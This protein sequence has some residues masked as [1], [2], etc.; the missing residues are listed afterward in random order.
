MRGNYPLRR[1]HIN[2]M[3]TDLRGI[4]IF[5]CRTRARAIYV[6]Q[7]EKQTLKERI[8]Q[9]WRNSHNEELRDWIQEFGEHL[10]VYYFEVT[11]YNLIR[12]IEARLI[13]WFKPLANIR[14]NPRK[15]KG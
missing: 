6:G 13:R 4:Y 7:S 2:A 10:D 11:K 12:R 15:S 3:P 9:E 1:L 14:G 8:L 5:W